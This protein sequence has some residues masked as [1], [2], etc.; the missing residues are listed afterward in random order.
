MSFRISPPFLGFS[1]ALTEYGLY[2]I[3]AQ[4]ATD[5]YCSYS[6]FFFLILQTT[7][8]GICEI[9]LSVNVLVTFNIIF[10]LCFF[11]ICSKLFLFCSLTCS[12]NIVCF[13]LALYE[14]VAWY[15][16]IIIANTYE[17]F[18][19]VYQHWNKCLICIF[20]F[21]SH[22]NSLSLVL[23]LSPFYRL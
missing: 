1:L 23:L 10:D 9:R 12:S 14:E 22:N 8:K 15:G 21:N 19:R 20:S 18:F 7:S 16:G 3:I 4:S 13:S 11:T 17:H 5:R 2:S 6:C